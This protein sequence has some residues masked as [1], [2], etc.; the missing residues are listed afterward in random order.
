MN[1]LFCIAYRAIILTILIIFQL[2]AIP[3]LTVV[4]VIDQFAQ[5]YMN[6]LGNNFNYAFKMLQEKGINYTNA[7]HCHGTPT[8]ATGHNALNTG[9]L[10]DKH[11]I[12][13]NGWK[14]KNGKKIRYDRDDST[15]SLVFSDNGLQNYGN[16]A[17]KIKVKGLT[18]RFVSKSKKYKSFSLS[19]KSRAAIGMAGK[20]GKPIW[21]DENSGIF[22]T[23]KAF[24]KKMP[25][26]VSDFNRKKDL[27]NKIKNKK[28]K[29]CYPAKS[30]YYKLK[31]INFHKNTNYKY[32][33]FD[34]TLILNDA[35]YTTT[36]FINKKVKT[37][38]EKKESFDGFLKSPFAN[39]YLLDLAK[40][41]IKKN[42]KKQDNMLLWV[43]LSPLDKLGHVYG[44]QSIEVIDMIYHLDKQIGHF[45]NYLKNKFGE[46][47]ILFVLTADHGVENLVEVSK[48]KG[49]KGYRIQAD[50]LIQEMNRHVKNKY[51]VEDLVVMFKTSQFYFDKNKFNLFS[52]KNK[53]K[54]IKDLKE[55]IL[56]NKGV[57]KVWSYDELS[58]LKCKF[59]SSEN[60]Y[61]RQMYPKRSGDL[62]C[63]PKK[64]CM[65]TTYTY[66][67]GHR[68]AYGYNT[69][70]PL[71]IYQKGKFENKKIDKKVWIPQLPVTIAKM[72]KLDSLPA[73]EFSTLPL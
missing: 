37:G 1:R 9:T 50:E 51:N 48:K 71:I 42:L 2:S 49:K 8:T 11:G 30:K 61:K 18:D 38:E 23:S 10:A 52:A 58:N 3:K 54:I 72:L 73:S 60:F 28:W 33:I 55:I 63:M 36:D 13:L 35:I 17:K 25:K 66:G 27:K 53:L 14:Q 68:S 5:H 22:T 20:S 4:M 41:C 69:N 19:H 31:D 29:L 34:E 70:V 46:Q 16:S 67:A 47:N 32:A 65:F 56:S 39:K 24:F 12:I 44:P 40:A 6:R 64:Y 7:H 43:S 57:K 59:N 15:Q 26:W 45:Y 21:F 62:I